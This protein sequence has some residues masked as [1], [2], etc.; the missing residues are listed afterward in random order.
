[1]WTIR[2]GEEGTIAAFGR[3]RHQNIVKTMAHLSVDLMELYALK[4]V[5]DVEM[6]R[7]ET[8]W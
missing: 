7:V 1:L 5:S 3:R 8:R 6:R 4:E 2:A